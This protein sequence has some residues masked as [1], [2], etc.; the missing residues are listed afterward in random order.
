G[1]GTL[2]SHRTFDFHGREFTRQWKA[3][4]PLR[5]HARSAADI[6]QAIDFAKK[7]NHKTTLVGLSQGDELADALLRSGLPTVLRVD[8]AYRFPDFNAGP[9]PLTFQA[10][11]S[12][13]AALAAAKAAKPLK[14]AL[15]GMEYDPIADLQTI[16]ALA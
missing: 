3:G 6:S 5:I 9:D 12:V 8:N 10:D 4:L 11:L 1:V 15:A 7:H 2:E 13:G 16:A 14:L